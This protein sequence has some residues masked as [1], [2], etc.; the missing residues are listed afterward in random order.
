M[1][2]SLNISRR[3]GRHAGKMRN[4]I[5]LQMRKTERNLMRKDAYSF[6]KEKA[7]S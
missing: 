3:F 7:P 1:A 4:Q 6:G 5:E 2:D